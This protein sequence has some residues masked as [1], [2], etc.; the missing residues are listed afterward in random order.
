MPTNGTTRGLSALAGFGLFLTA[1]VFCYLN[2]TTS[3]AFW[4]MV[5]VAGVVIC[6][7]AFASKWAAALGVENG[8]AVVADKVASIVPWAAL[9]FDGIQALHFKHDGLDGMM[10]GIAIIA[11]VFLVAFGVA[12]SVASL[13]GQKY[14]DIAAAAEE[15]G[16]RL[17][18]MSEAAHGRRN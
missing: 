16:S 2:A 5:Y 10:A 9:Y 7:L 11:L 15:A 1:I 17:N 8:L 6:S 12:D 3:T 13:L 14:R 4:S 18:A